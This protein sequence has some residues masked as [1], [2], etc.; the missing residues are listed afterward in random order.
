MIRYDVPKNCTGGCQKNAFT[1]AFC[2]E[3]RGTYRKRSKQLRDISVDEDKITGGQLTLRRPD[4]S[5]AERDT[6]STGPNEGLSKVERPESNAQSDT[7]VKIYLL[8]VTVRRNLVLLHPKHLDRLEVDQCVHSL[9]KNT[10]LTE[11]RTYITT[12][13]P[14]RASKFFT[15]SINEYIPVGNAKCMRDESVLER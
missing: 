14:C 10:N 8:E 1:N 3:D 6:N 9:I 11:V 12:C 4:C 13:R 15:F 5:Q 7:E 2:K